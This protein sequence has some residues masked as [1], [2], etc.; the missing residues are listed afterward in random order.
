M[1]AK[2]R[3][4]VSPR[5]ILP[6]YFASEPSPVDAR[7]ALALAKPTPDES[8][9]GV[10]LIL[11]DAHQCIEI[12][13][14]SRLGLVRMAWSACGRLLACAQNAT[15]VIYDA[16]G[17]LQLHP[18]SKNVQ[19]LGFDSDRRL[20]CLAGKRLEARC[21]DG[22]QA[23]ID[24][25]ECA[26]MGECAGYC[27][28]EDAGVCVYL[29]DGSAA[30]QVA[31]LPDIGGAATIKMSMRGPFVV[32]A[33]LF[34]SVRDRAR[35]RIVRIDMRTSAMDA[36][37]DAQVGVGFNAGPGL[38]A[39]ALAHGD[40]LAAYENGACT[41]VWAL[42]PNAAP[43]PIS[44]DGLEV[45]DIAVHADGRRLAILAADTRDALGGSQRHL[46]VLHKHASGAWQ[47]ATL[48]PGVH[49]MP[50][51]RHDGEL[52]V[53][54]GDDG[55]WSREI[56]AGVAV[57]SIAAPSS[58]EATFVST[59]RADY[60]VVRL[61]G[62]RDRQAGIIL[63]PRVHQQFVAGAQSFFFHHFLFAIARTLAERGYAVVTLNGPGAIGRGRARR[64]LRKRDGSYLAQVRAAIDNLARTLRDEGCQSIGIM[65]GSLAA[66]PA[67]R[68]VGPGTP[69]TAAAFVAPL[70]DA[71]IPL[72]MP[73]AHYL[74]EDPLVEPLDEA[75]ARLAVPSL[76][77]HGVLDD[78]VPLEQIKLFEQRAPRELIEL[79]L[80]ENE[81]HI[82]KESESWR[83]THHAIEAFFAC[84]LTAG[85]SRPE[86]AL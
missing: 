17:D 79:R 51:W 82:F 72:T 64:E 12:F 2:I 38:A 40:V 9:V 16:A 39:F 27:C 3:S 73:L 85:V 70:F 29:H 57:A 26:A 60:D 13:R 47:L 66:G 42:S 14:F 35:A 46:V 62:P 83:H 34:P 1:R 75:A 71:A 8:D 86:R 45:F 30:R 49:D 84:H 50:R 55:R 19:W 20:W 36:L 59:R 77:V 53:L 48:Q 44:P 61:P 63:L 76:V 43:D 21:G 32:V 67:L 80:F 58:F 69:L 37:L 74:I 6:Y 7:T 54:R 11:E 65:A 33:A 25:V 81:G 31:C 52:D 10:S 23:A 68:A 78:V 22:V 18:I 5:D 15:L 41:R 56:H 24:G 4:E 28:R